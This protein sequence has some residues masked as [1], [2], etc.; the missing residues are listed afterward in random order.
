M[1]KSVTKFKKVQKNA[2][3][4]GA[5]QSARAELRILCKK[6]NKTSGTRFCIVKNRENEA[7]SNEKCV[8]HS[9]KTTGPEGNIVKN[10]GS[11]SLWIPTLLSTVAFSPCFT[12][13]SSGRILFVSRFTR[14]SLPHCSFCLFFT[15]QKRVRHLFS[16]FLHSVRRPVCAL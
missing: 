4:H 5:N 1:Y 9:T 7:W 14:F 6:Q 15:M 3:K 8:K 16:R 11:A 2:I 12:M 13:F 10:N